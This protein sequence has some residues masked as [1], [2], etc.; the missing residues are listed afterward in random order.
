MAAV[1]F[2]YSPFVL[3][4]EKESGTHL[5]QTCRELGVSVVCYAPLGR[6]MLSEAFTSQGLTSGP[7]DPHAARFP[8]FREEN[9][10]VNAK[11]VSKFKAF[12]DTKGCKTSQLALAWILKQGEEMIPIPGTKRIKY[13]E[14]NWGGLR[15]HLTDQDE[16]EIR[17]FVETT[18]LAGGASPAE[19]KAFAFVDTKEESVKERLKL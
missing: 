5:L 15:V 13:L 9:L 10:S 17:K 11:V 3:D 18:E 2:E 14:E 8:Q 19:S 1:Q 16:T 12:A 6:G 7:E 4:L